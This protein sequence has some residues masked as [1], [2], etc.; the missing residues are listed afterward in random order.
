LGSA[1]VGCPLSF[2]QSTHLVN[3]PLYPIVTAGLVALKSIR[4][5]LPDHYSD[6]SAAEK[7]SLQ[8]MGIGQLDFNKMSPAGQISNLK[9]IRLKFMEE[10]K[11]F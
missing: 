1:L 4:D 3:A 8:A 5:T 7:D 6:L 10:G 2:L 9:D 11:T